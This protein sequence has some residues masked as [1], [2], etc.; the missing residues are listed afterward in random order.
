MDEDYLIDNGIL[1][2]WN[3]KK[4]S[5]IVIPNGVIKIAGDNIHNSSPLDK[6]LPMEGPFYS[7][8]MRNEN[9]VSV[10]M[11]D[12]VKV[13]GAK[14][15]EHC[16]NLKTVKLSKNLKEVE[17]MAFMGTNIEEL[18]FPEGFEKIGWNSFSLIPNLKTITF[19]KSLKE[20]SED[21]LSCNKDTVI[22]APKDSFAIE[23]AKKHHI[24]YIEI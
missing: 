19:P 6:N 11:S 21:G 3:N 22:K 17:I 24:K 14:A 13:V 4:D 20:I 18:V 12:S 15:F 8:F 7:A 23:Y 5:H 1:K 9:I 16:S 10:E 2:A